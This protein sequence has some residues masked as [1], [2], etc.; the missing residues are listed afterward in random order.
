M[1]L[2]EH[3]TLEELT[4]SEIGARKGIDNTPGPFVQQNLL[5]LAKF[6]E[7]VRQYQKV[8]IL[9]RHLHGYLQIEKVNQ[10]LVQ[11]IQIGV[12]NNHLFYQQY[13]LTERI[14]DLQQVPY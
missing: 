11:I 1:N 13:Q 5:R 7:E 3:F 14:Q 10:N 8:V 9:L 4:A 6:L 12:D 2:T